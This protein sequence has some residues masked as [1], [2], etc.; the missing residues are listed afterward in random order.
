MQKYPAKKTRV[1]R[2]VISV[3]V[4]DPNKPEYEKDMNR[5]CDYIFNPLKRA[6][7]SLDAGRGRLNVDVQQQND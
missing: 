7:E 4:D 3:G 5:V 6:V 2:V 1:Y